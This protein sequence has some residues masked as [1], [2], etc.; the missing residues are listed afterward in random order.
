MI[1]PSDSLVSGRFYRVY[2]PGGKGLL[3]YDLDK[4]VPLG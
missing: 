1:I 4:D 2:I 3:K